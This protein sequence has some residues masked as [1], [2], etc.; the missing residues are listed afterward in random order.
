[1]RWFDLLR[2]K[3]PV[4]HTLAEGPS[5]TLK[6]DDPMRVFQIPDAAKLAGIAQNPR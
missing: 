3:V 2:Y 6:A 4:T 1:M 5:R